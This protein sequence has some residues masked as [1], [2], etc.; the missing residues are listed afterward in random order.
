MPLVRARP[1][2]IPPRYEPSGSAKP[3]PMIMGEND[4]E[5]WC[6]FAPHRS[7]DHSASIGNTR[8]SGSLRASSARLY[9]RRHPRRLIRRDVARAVTPIDPL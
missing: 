8:S 2:T 5:M 6:E 7:F 1:L 4:P 3:S 9:G